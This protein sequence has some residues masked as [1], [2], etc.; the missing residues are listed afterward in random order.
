MR[1]ALHWLPTAGVAVLVAAGAVAVPAIAGSDSGLPDRAPGEILEL[2]AGGSD[3][4]FSGTIDQS[5][6]LGL[7][8][9]PTSGVG[10]GVRSSSSIVELLTA[11]HTARVY[12]DGAG[13][14]RVQVLDRLAERDVIRN[15]S[16][17]WLYD[18]QEN[19][20]AHLTL[21]AHDR[22]PG[23]VP[24]PAELAQ[25]FLDR[26]DS[27]TEVT[28]DSGDR[29][30]GRDV[31]DL[32]LTPRSAET[33]IGDVT[34]SVDAETGLPLK[35][36]VDPQGQE[37]DAFTLA[38]T[39]IDFGVPAPDVFAFTPPEGA[40]VEEIGGGFGRSHYAYGMPDVVVTGSGWDTVVELPADVLGAA[41]Y[42]Q[43]T[44]LEQLTTA[45]PEG[46]ALQTT[47]VTVL[48]TSDG[49]ALAGAVPL[50]ALQA[51]AR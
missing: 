25:S 45:V 24:T 49:R 30:A 4:A 23:S 21:P 10:G 32:V 27:S 8:E 42:E 26:I 47:L 11:S 9:L 38:F 34:V 36:S 5:S 51:A 22:A 33:L 15:G 40:T 50:E 18:S 6:E 41:D 14:Q 3:T 12:S 28:V 20:A 46:R 43:R 35:V 1:N 19:E 37:Q 16:D 31:Y 29:V 48:L 7:P 39:D 2:I 17:V 13:G 44:L